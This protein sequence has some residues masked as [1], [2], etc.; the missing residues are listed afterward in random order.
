MSTIIAYTG[1]RN[2]L[3]MM[4]EVISSQVY[5]G[6]AEY[7][8]YVMNQNQIEFFEGQVEN[9]E[10]LVH[11][12]TLLGMEC[13]QSLCFLKWN[14]QAAIRESGSFNLRHTREGDL[15]LIFNGV[16]SNLSE[17]TEFL[18]T[19]GHDT[20]SFSEAD[21]M[22]ILI[23]E[24][25]KSGDYNL[26]DSISTALSLVE[27]EYTLVAMA[28]TDPHGIVAAMSNNTLA[29]GTGKE[30][31]LVSNQSRV[32]LDQTKNVTYLNNNEIAY[33]NMNQEVSI[34]TLS[35]NFEKKN[36]ASP[37]WKQEKEQMLLNDYAQ[38]VNNRNEPKA[39][40]T[41]S[42]PVVQASTKAGWLPS[43]LAG[44]TVKAIAFQLLVLYL[45]SVTA[46]FAGKMVFFEMGGA[47]VMATL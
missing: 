31:Y 15:A 5:K 23:N 2:A 39:S 33:I 18:E 47:E 40:N 17:L 30:D 35:G 8:I 6:S 11:L 21:I 22:A 26:K 45:V 37:L 13:N 3:P 27:G 20:S 12:N 28:N 32:L 46:D 43:S 16:V 24:N 41:S 44:L 1:N 4:K 14:E 7:G 36:Q 10:E 19:R 9:P 25:L 38:R 42:A 34:E 29:I